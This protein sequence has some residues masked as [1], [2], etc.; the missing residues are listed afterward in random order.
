MCARNREKVLYYIIRIQFICLACKA[1]L[2]IMLLFT[3]SCIFRFGKE[4]H[5]IICIF[6]DNSSSIEFECFECVRVCRGC[7]VTCAPGPP[8]PDFN[9]TDLTFRIN[10]QN[11]N[12]KYIFFCV[13]RFGIGTMFDVHTLFQTNFG[14]DFIRLSIYNDNDVDTVY[15]LDM[16]ITLRI[17]VIYHVAC[18][19][20]L[21]DY[22][23]NVHVSKRT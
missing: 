15:T 23:Y 11:A 14:N 19:C 12:I 2:C 18:V 10:Q 21:C 5:L 6:H 9:G 13:R 17:S 20:V 8:K 1:G 16:S 3:L 4:N 22:A 7:A